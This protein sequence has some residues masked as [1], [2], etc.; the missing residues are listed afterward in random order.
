MATPIPA[1]PDLEKSLDDMA[2]SLQKSGYIILPAI[3]PE[4]LLADLFVHFK[5]MDD[6]KFKQAGIGREGDFQFNR[7]IRTDQIHWLEGSHPVTRAYFDIV[8]QI[9][10]G[11]NRRLFLGLFDYECHY[12]FYPQ[13][14][15]YKKH[16]DAFRGQNTRILSTV[17]YL[18]PNWSPGD[19]GELLI[20]NPDGTEVIE[21]VEPYFGTMAVFL[22]EEYPH[23]VLPVNSPR[24]S[25]T[26]WFRKNNSLGEAIDPGR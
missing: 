9:R 8:E 22:S 13:G 16:Y 25:V 2:E 20:Y 17:L 5:S 21:K 23:E 11:L 24:Y 26:G 4:P 14:A 19:G 12:A 15:F 7:F 1:Y 10:E 3:I 6:E 18:N